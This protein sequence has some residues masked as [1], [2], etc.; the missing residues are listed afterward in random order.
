MGKEELGW[1]AES[2][3]SMFTAR[4]SHSEPDSPSCYDSF[5]CS[6]ARFSLWCYSAPNTC[7]FASQTELCLPG[8]D[9]PAS[10]KGSP[11][12]QPLYHCSCFLFDVAES[13]ATL[14]LSVIT[15]RLSFSSGLQSIKRGHRKFAGCFEKTFIIIRQT[16]QS[17]SSTHTS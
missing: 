12:L 5:P 17:Y 13:Y 8:Q 11:S 1:R 7:T 9:R 14:T 4:A 10:W 3:R 2:V 16:P 15:G 6:N